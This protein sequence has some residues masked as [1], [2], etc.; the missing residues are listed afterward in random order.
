MEHNRFQSNFV[1]PGKSD[2][3]L[4]NK[5]VRFALLLV[6]VLLL[7]VAVF[8]AY[9][10]HALY[11]PSV[12]E[13]AGEGKMLLYVLEFSDKDGEFISRSAAGKAVTDAV[14]GTHLGTVV[15]VE[16]GDAAASRPIIEGMS[17]T[18]PKTVLVTVSLSATY[19]EGEGYR[20]GDI[21]I[22]MGSTYTVSI[23][24]SVATGICLKLK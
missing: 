15:R 23:T 5:Q 21:R 3:V 19:F 1:S 17:D 9:F 11:A 24:G 6:N 4:L 7:A 16:K 22:A 8:F 2:A 13:Q 14:T 10:L 20:A 12:Q 18:A